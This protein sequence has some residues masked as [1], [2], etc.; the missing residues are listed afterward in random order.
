MCLETKTNPSPMIYQPAPV[1]DLGEWPSFWLSLK[2]LSESESESVR[3][4]WRSDCLCNG[5]F[6]IYCF[7]Q[8]KELTELCPAHCQ[9]TYVSKPVT[10]NVESEN[11]LLIVTFL[12]HEIFPA[13]NFLALVSSRTPRVSKKVTIKQNFLNP[14]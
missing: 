2:R 10:P 5:V 7:C 6:S 11:F 1:T 4:K 8:F 3:H 12:E 13:G 9:S 14:H